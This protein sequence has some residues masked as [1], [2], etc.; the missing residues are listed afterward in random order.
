MEWREE[1]KTIEHKVDFSKVDIQKVEDYWD[2][3]PCN[4]RHSALPIG[5]REYFDEVETRKYKVEPHI[6]I[7]AEFSKYNG[8]KVLEIGCGLGTETV[9]FVRAGAIVTVIELS[10]KSLSLCAE[11]LKVF[12]LTATLIQGN[13]EQIDQLVESKDFDLVWSFGVIH[14]TP[15]P[16]RIIEQ[17]YKVLKPSGELKIMVYSKVSYKLFFLMKETNNWD[18]SQKGIDTLVSEYSEAQVGCPVTFSYTLHEARK[19]VRD[20]EL[21]CVTEIFKDHIFCWDIGHYREYRYVKDD[22]WANVDDDQLRALEKE[23]GWHTC[24]SAI[25]I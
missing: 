22:V 3:R 16:D 14:H 8:K 25:R 10:Q 20:G 7:F 15:H 21:F 13:G 17:C 4:I 9:N 2:S 24:I 5:T 6:P 18:F 12:G 1:F 11:R 23:L 19:L